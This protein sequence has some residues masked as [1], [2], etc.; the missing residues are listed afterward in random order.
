MN[1]KI[2]KAYVEMKK[3]QEKKGKSTKKAEEK[4]PTP[5]ARIREM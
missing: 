4:K 3:E 1:S 5:K 2:Y